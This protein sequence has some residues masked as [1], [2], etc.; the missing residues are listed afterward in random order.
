MSS[1]SDTPPTLQIH[2]KTSFATIT[3]PTL[4]ATLHACQTAI[5]IRLRDFETSLTVTVTDTRT[6]DI[7]KVLH[8]PKT[9]F[10]LDDLFF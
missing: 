2:Y 9:D 1:S 5:G 10:P 8:Y 7:I 3:D 4:Y 6:G